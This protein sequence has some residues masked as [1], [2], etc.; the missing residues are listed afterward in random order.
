MKYRPC[1]VVRSNKSSDN[2]ACQT[3]NFSEYDAEQRHFLIHH[4]PRKE[5]S[6][7]HR[8]NTDQGKLHVLMTCGKDGGQD[9]SHTDGW[10]IVE[11][12]DGAASFTA[13]EKA[14]GRFGGTDS[15][16]EFATNGESRNDNQVNLL[17]PSV[18]T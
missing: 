6:P 15:T 1:N 3:H 8:N 16:A 2:A 11:I 13:Y 10:A 18:A 7:A 14:M 17:C 5:R 4:R 9:V 12:Q